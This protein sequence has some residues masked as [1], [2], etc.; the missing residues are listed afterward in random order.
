VLRGGT[1]A[2]TY[3]CA[4]LTSKVSLIFLRLLKF[5]QDLP[6]VEPLYRFSYGFLKPQIFDPNRAVRNLCDTYAGLAILAVF[7][8]CP[9]QKF[10]KSS[11]AFIGQKEIEQFFS[12]TTWT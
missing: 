12:T 7:D 11:L 1:D 4:G 8:C 10:R 6:P 3:G 5:P 2:D 9:G